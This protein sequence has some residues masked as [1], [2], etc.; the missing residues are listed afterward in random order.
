MRLKKIVLSLATIATILPAIAFGQSAGTW[1]DVGRGHSGAGG[2]ATGTFQHVDTQSRVGPHGSLASG[3]AVGAGPNGLSLSHSI[4]MNAGGRGTAHNFN[5]SVGPNGA[6]ISR[7]NV[8]STGGDSRVIA[9]G[10]SNVG[11]PWGSPSG[12]SHA[13]GYGTHTH[14]QTHAQTTRSFRPPM[15]PSPFGGPFAGGPVSGPFGRG[16]FGGGPFGGGPFGPRHF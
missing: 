11:S 14:A 15:P 8:N 13:T 9:G 10:S 6:H 2:S 7:G 5:L 1:V 12:G 4:G 16:P 3:V